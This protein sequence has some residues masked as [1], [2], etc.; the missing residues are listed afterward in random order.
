MGLGF[1]F[2]VFFNLISILYWLLQ[3][4]KNKWLSIVTLLVGIPF[5]N[6]L[7][8]INLLGNE[9]TKENSLTVATYNMQFAK[10]ILFADEETE[11]RASKKYE[12]F[13]TSIDDIDVLC[14]QEFNDKTKEH[15]ENATNFSH[16]YS[17]DKKTVAIF[18][19][20]PIL[21]AGKIDFGSQVN[22]CLWAD[23]KKQDDTVRVY[24]VHLQSNQDKAEPPI[25]LDMKSKEQLNTSGV[26]GLLKF[27]NKYTAMRAAQSE[28]IRKHQEKSP[29]PSVICGDFNDPPQSYTYRVISKGLNDS[30]REKGLGLGA[31][32]GGRI[33]ALRI[34]YILTDPTLDV[35][36]HE[37]I[38]NKFSDHYI[39]KSRIGI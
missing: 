17:I 18:S 39:V 24:T 28:E 12:A 11:K 10:P 16:Q 22:I 15:L 32:Y 27:Y 34:D 30:F 9:A 8:G 21:D 31:T 19:K 33:P 2:L 26:V 25:I 35:L 20:Y 4:S 14:L 13:L 5:L 3:R 23:V 29:Y 6:N 1:P 37:V 7:V 38:E 36:S